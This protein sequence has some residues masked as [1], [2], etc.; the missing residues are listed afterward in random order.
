M[1]APWGSL[2]LLWGAVAVG[3]AVSGCVIDRTGESLSFRFEQRIENTV[4]RQRS[5]ERDLGAEQRRVDDISANMEQA[6]QRMAEGG[7]TLEAFIAELQALR[8]E[9][10]AARHELLTSTR[11]VDDIDFWLASVDARVGRIEQHLKLEP[12]QVGPEP[13][14]APPPSAGATGVIPPTDP[15]PGP[16]DP[17]P[18]TT[19]G[20]GADVRLSSDSPGTGAEDLV[21]L[22]TGGSPPTA[23]SADDAA[24]ADALLSIKAED[25]EKAGSKLT[26]YLK[27][28]PSGR[29]AVQAQ[30]LVARC[31][32]ELGKYKV[33]VQEF[34]RVASPESGTPDPTWAPRAMWMQ[35]LAFVE[36]GTNNDLAAAR[37][38]LS[39]LVAAWPKSPEAARARKK[40]EQLK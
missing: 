7:A 39:E 2:A 37:L 3:A 1:S 12:M 29:F 13:G 8:G 21:A 17:P 18:A 19:P 11:R 35:G 32:F 9:L 22:V 6:R 4:E 40:L 23:T 36:L 5:L 26:R 16:T 30:Y 10:A 33:A 28:Y 38:F 31:Y 34:E 14:A 20:D 27:K 24:F 15:T 25:W